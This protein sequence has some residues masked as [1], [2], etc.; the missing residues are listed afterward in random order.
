MPL[1]QLENL[2]GTPTTWKNRLT[3]RNRFDE[4]A[5]T[6]ELFVAPKGNIK[7]TLDGSE[8]RNGESYNE[9][10]QLSDQETTVCVFAECDGLEEKRNFTF[11]E[12]GSKEIPIVKDKPAILVS[13][14]QN[15]W[16]AQPK[17]T[18]GSKIAQEK[19]IEFEQ[20]SLMVG[21]APQVI[22]LSLGE[23]KISAQ[24]VE[25]ALAHFKVFLVLKH[26]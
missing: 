4:I 24:F 17:P 12:S 13:P 6:V 26:L 9:P 23:M 1:I 2:T 18:E 8:A 25:T 5:R 15:E 14:L 19:G 20:V 10:I 21:S 11:A 16:T 3:I 22:H 7:F